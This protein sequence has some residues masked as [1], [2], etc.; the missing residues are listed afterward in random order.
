M[1]N[2]W[3]FNEGLPLCQFKMQEVLPQ[4]SE[5]LEAYLDSHVQEAT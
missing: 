2:Y 3:W 1:F 4:P 5:T